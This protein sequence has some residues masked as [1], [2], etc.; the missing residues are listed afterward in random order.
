MKLTVVGCA[1]A[2]TRRA[3]RASSSYLIEHDGHAVL[4]DLGQ[5]TF[6]ELARYRPPQ[7]VDAVLISHLHADH[8]VDL[9]PLRHYLK[10]EAASDAA[11]AL[12]GPAELRRRLDSLVGEP[13]FIDALPGE[14]LEPGRFELGGFDIEARHVT[15]IADSYA[16]RISVPRADAP[17]LVYSGDCGVADD[18][19]PLLRPGDYLLCEAALGAGDGRTGVHLTASEAAR[20]AAEAGASRLVLT[21]LQ[22]VVDEDRARDQAAQLFGGTLELA[23][24]GLVVAIS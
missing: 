19:L 8:L 17:G 2:W 13:G 20:V 6:S 24:P 21:H 9:V 1:A 7:S 11:V 22:D 15:H 14:P 4:F 23:R 5:G 12:H 3:G 18:L 16:F 10:Y